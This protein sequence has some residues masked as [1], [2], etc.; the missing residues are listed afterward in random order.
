VLRR[1]V[2]GVCR[3]AQRDAQG[4]GKQT[5]DG[6]HGRSGDENGSLA[7]RKRPA[8]A[9]A[10][11]VPRLRALQPSAQRR[12]ESMCATQHSASAARS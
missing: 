3:Q 10:G 12:S 2:V 5:Q 11:P 1:V 4:Q 7:C 8:A 6:T 9:N